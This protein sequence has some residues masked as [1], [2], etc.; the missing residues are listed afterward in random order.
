MQRTGRQAHAVLVGILVQYDF[1]MRT[2]LQK[3]LFMV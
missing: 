3:S 2:C 1:I